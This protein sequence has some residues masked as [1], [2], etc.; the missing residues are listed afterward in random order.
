MS[1]HPFDQTE[2]FN[3]YDD[4]DTDSIT[5]DFQSMALSEMQYTSPPSWEM[6]H[7]LQPK[8][9]A[10]ALRRRNA[11]VGELPDAPSRSCN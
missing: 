10:Y 8:L 3:V 2:P 5:E 4:S 9:P 7:S 11:I 6:D 1:A